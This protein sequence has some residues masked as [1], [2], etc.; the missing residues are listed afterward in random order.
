MQRSLLLSHNSK[1]GGKKRHHSQVKDAASGV[2][3]LQKQASASLHFADLPSLNPSVSAFNNFLH[4]TNTYRPFCLSSCSYSLS[5]CKY[6]GS[7]HSNQS[8]HSLKLSIILMESNYTKLVLHHNTQTDLLRLSQ[9]AN[10]C[11]GGQ[12]DNVTTTEVF[13]ECLPQWDQ[14]PEYSLQQYSIDTHSK[15]VLY[16]QS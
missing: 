2:H 4:N 12:N 10:S 13:T 11:K 14:A 9:A 3:L 5:E 15:P 8:T 1:Q 16:K 7:D 6:S